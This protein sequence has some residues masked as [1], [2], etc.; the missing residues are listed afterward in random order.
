MS[1]VTDAVERSRYEIRV[2]DGTLAG[3]AE[4]RD[5][6]GVRVFTH[7]EIKREFEGQG[8][9]STLV[10]AALDA[11]RAS[12]GSIVPLCPFVEHFVTEHAEYGD[13]V[14]DA[15]DARLRH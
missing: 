13:L 5:M 8:L 1:E 14:D 11:V 4:Y 3:F 2:A 9:G 12:G 10:R 6:D 7:T 15:L